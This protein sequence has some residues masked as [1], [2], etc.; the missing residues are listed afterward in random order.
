MRRR[1][2]VP[3]QLDIPLVWDTADGPEPS[4]STREALSHRGNDAPPAWRARVPLASVADAGVALVLC[5]VTGAVAVVAGADLTPGQ[6]VA[7]GLGGFQ[8]VSIVAIASLWAWR[9]TLG[10]LL[11]GLSFASP[12]DFARA[13]RVWAV[14]A[15]VLPLAGTPLLLSRG[16]LERL[17][18]A[19]IRCRSI[20]A[21]A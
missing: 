17:A 4:R 19:R 5:A 1:G 14:W 3:E 20:R 7:T 2:R 21:N 8:I 6:L 10:M 13:G 9:G 18:R 15:V 12:L 16:F 11:M